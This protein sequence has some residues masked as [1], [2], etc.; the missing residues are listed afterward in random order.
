MN[1]TIIIY[2]VVWMSW[3]LIRA[4]RQLF[5]HYRPTL[6]LILCGFMFFMGLSLYLYLPFTHPKGLEPHNKDAFY[7]FTKLVD[8]L[9]PNFVGNEEHA[10]PR[11]SWGNT[12]TL[13][14]W[15]HHI[16]RK[17]YGTSRLFPS[18]SSQTWIENLKDN[19]VFYINQPEFNNSVVALF[20]L[21]LARQLF[22]LTQGRLLDIGNVC[23]D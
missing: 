21:G 20:A 5:S 9:I 22:V 19:L 18:Q 14:G 8:Q 2:L 4:R 17:D 13:E 15:L 6:L 11:Y 7:Q 16:L 3:V 10:F 23:D 1:R 12:R